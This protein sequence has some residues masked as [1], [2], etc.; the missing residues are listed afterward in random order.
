MNDER[1]ELLGKINDYFRAN[2]RYEFEQLLSDAFAKWNDIC[3]IKPTGEKY[4]I[5]L[6]VKHLEGS[7]FYDAKDAAEKLDS[8]YRTLVSVCGSEGYEGIKYLLDYAIS[9]A[10]TR[11]NALEVPKPIVDLARMDL[12]SIWNREKPVL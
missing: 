6:Q 9:F 8:Q 3:Q 12:D 10:A 5:C 11:E 2:E 1:E 4:E 7:G